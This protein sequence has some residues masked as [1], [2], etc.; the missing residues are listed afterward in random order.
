MAYYS[1]KVLSQQEV[2]LPTYFLAL[3][4]G[5]DVFNAS[6]NDLEKFSQE[7]FQNGV[8]ILEVHQLDDLEQVPSE[9]PLI[10]S[11]SPIPQL[12]ALR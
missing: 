2:V 11:S 8:K 12:G 7:L 5:I 1:F 9:V 10:S 6:V 4:E 3:G